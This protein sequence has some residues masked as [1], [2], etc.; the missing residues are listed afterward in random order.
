MQIKKHGTS[1]GFILGLY[2][3]QKRAKEVQEKIIKTYQLS[4]LLKYTKSQ[5]EQ[6]IIIDKFK[7]NELEPFLYRMPKE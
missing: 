6:D 5:A 4:E 3:T 7:K 1:Q 2:E